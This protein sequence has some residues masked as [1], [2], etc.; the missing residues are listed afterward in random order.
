MSQNMGR[1]LDEWKG[2]SSFE[3][4]R[5]MGDSFL[6]RIWIRKTTVRYGCPLAQIRQGKLFGAIFTWSTIG[7]KLE[8]TSHI[9]RG[10]PDEEISDI[11]WLRFKWPRIWD[12]R[13]A[14]SNC[15][16]G[17]QLLFLDVPCERLGIINVP[18][19]NSTDRRKSRRFLKRAGGVRLV[20]RWAECEPFLIIILELYVS[21]YELR[22]YAEHAMTELIR[23]WLGSTLAGGSEKTL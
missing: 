21:D 19:E 5:H 1:L 23:R 2:H 20:H 13:N 4:P 14:V 10:R 15:S 18:V 9:R 7:N 16:R 17:N 22:Q 6:A 11:S 3:P 12:M 8:L